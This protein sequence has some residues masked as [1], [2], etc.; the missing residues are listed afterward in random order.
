MKID[1]NHPFHKAFT[2]LE[3]VFVIVII[4]IL[5]FMAASSFQRNTLAEATDQVISHIR[6]TQH[7]AM[8]DDKF[9]PN[10][11][12]AATWYK[13]RWHIAFINNGTNWYYSIGSDRDQS[14]TVDASEFAKDPMDSNKNLDGATNENLNLTKKYGVTITSNTC[15]TANKLFF[16]YLGRPMKASS[17]TYAQADMV[18]GSCSI[19]LSNGVDTPKTITVQGETGY[20]RAN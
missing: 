20:V 5:S 18:Q 10:G 17:N 1:L 13:E 8:M 19:V 7:L 15:A 14:N 12:N 3:L 6:Y 16:D 11:T 9:K 2:M 4:G